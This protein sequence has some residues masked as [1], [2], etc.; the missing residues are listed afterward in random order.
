MYNFI[1]ASKALSESDQVFWA[2]LRTILKV[3][4]LYILV[5]GKPTKANVVWRSPMKAAI[6]KL[7]ETN[8]LYKSVQEEALMMQHRK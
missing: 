5:N 8:W 1:L 3:V 6:S 4:Q 7:K 2:T